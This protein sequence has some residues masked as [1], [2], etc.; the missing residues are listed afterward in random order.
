MILQSTLLVICELPDMTSLLS[1]ECVPVP[2]KQKPMVGEQQ[3]ALDLLS[4]GLAG[5]SV[6]RSAA[7][8]F[9]TGDGEPQEDE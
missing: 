2:S 7:P 6:I 1:L 9:N 4:F 5:R 8:Q 3:W